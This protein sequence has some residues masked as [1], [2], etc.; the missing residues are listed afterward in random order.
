V[1][2]Q[3]SSC[4]LNIK[5]CQL[6]NLPILGYFRTSMSTRAT[7]KRKRQT[8]DNDLVETFQ[9]LFA[10]R[11]ELVTTFERVKLRPEEIQNALKCVLKDKEDEVN[12]D[13]DVDD[14]RVDDSGINRSIKSMIHPAIFDSLKKHQKE[15]VEFL[16]NRII[17][18]VENNQPTTDGEGAILAHMMG[19]GK[20]LTILAFLHTVL[21]NKK[22]KH[23][24]QRILIVVPKNVI[25][26][27]KNEFKKW[28][29]SKNLGANIKEAVLT[30]RDEHIVRKRRVKQWKKGK[31]SKKILILGHEMLVNLTN[32]YEGFNDLL[33]PDLVIFDEAHKLKNDK[34]EMHKTIKKMATRKK[35]F[36]TGTPIQ[37]NLEELYNIIQII[38]SQILGKKKSFI[39]KFEK[40]IVKGQTKDAE[41]KDVELMIERCYELYGKVSNVVH[42]RGV[43]VIIDDMKE[44][45]EAT[46]M[47]K[48]T[49]LQTKLIKQYLK[50]ID[51][52]KRSPFKDCNNLLRI[53]THPQ[54][55]YNQ[56]NE[57][58]TVDIGKV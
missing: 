32:N 44:K 33:T 39:A 8:E 12:I 37:N 17:G 18:P 47:I 21:S 4:L 14:E 9:W 24:V 11:P 19:T 16:F 49:L 48:P 35:I 27:W 40:P 1:T 51:T 45:V 38:N 57:A 10:K 2:F 20:T 28:I 30:E 56:K 36:L 42:R 22:L 54:V 43:Q 26:N 23:D 5:W 15:G 41:D 53:L 29:K 7:R 50:N 6:F 13:Y 3:L 52:K 34:T 46:L 31:S 58:N 55:F 25:L